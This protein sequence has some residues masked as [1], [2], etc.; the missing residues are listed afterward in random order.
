[1]LGVTLLA[2]ALLLP[3]LLGHHIVAA[4]VVAEDA[5]TE[6]RNDSVI[7]MRGLAFFFK[8]KIK[9]NTCVVVRYF[10]SGEGPPAV[11][12]AQPPGELALAVQAVGDLL[13]H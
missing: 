3:A 6:P 1:M 7:E 5:A 13:V 12:S 9:I 8:K 4:A 11:M 10:G 2:A